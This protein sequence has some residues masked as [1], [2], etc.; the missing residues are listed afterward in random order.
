MPAVVRPS[1]RSSS[2]RRPGA[3]G[4]G[5]I[6]Q[7]RPSTGAAIE[8]E[9][10]RASDPQGRALIKPAEYLPP[11]EE[12]DDDYPLWLTTGRAVYHFHTRTKTGR[13]PEL[14]AAA[15]DVFV[16]IARK[17][18]AAL[19][20]KTGDLLEVASRRGTV[21]A[22]A[23]VADILPGHLFLPFHYGYWDLDPGAAPTRAANELTV[24]AWD[25]VSKQPIFKVAAV[26]LARAED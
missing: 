25:P 19:G 8:P 21:R 18:A 23:R 24:T 1:A 26:R 6:A 13:C 12:P 10:Y 17:D 5:T 9:A 2:A 15:P 22:P 7:T 4:S 11:F 3:T 14:Q 20:V 16:E